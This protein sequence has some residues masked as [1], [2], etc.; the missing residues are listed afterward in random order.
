M[1]ICKQRVLMVN[2][3]HILFMYIYFIYKCINLVP[4]KPAILWVQEEGVIYF[5]FRNF[6]LSFA[7]IHLVSPSFLQTEQMPFNLVEG[8]EGQSSVL[9]LSHVIHM[10][11]THAHTHIALSF[12]LTK[13]LSTVYLMIFSTNFRIKSRRIQLVS[14]G[15]LSNPVHHFHVTEKFVKVCI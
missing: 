10:E 13:R 14:I 4:W 1:A 12:R 3:Y 15:F 6:I 2:T 5:F 11:G 9:H 7:N 8:I